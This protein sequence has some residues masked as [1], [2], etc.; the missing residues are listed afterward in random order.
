MIGEII[1]IGDELTSGQRLDTNSQWISQRLGELG[2]NVL[3]HTT[4]ADDLEAGVGVFRAAIERADVIIASGGL[5]PT[6]DDLTREVLAGATGIQLIEDPDAL[7]AIA[8]MFA[9]RGREMPERNK[10]QAL[11]PERSQVIPNPHGTAPGIAM[12]IARELREPCRLFALPGVPAELFEMW[13][14]SVAP[15]IAALP[16][17]RLVICHRRLKCFGIGESQ[18]EAMLPDLI[19]R[20]RS[21]SVGITVHEA[22]ITLRV[23]AAGTTPGAA[24]TLMEP[25]IRTIRE[26]LGHL[27]FG[28]EDDELPD[29]VARLLAARGA[30]LA[31][32]EWGTAGLIADWLG[33][34]ADLRDRYLGGLVVRSRPALQ[35]ILDLRVEDDAGHGVALAEAM[36]ERTRARLE[37][38]YALAVGE[39]PHSDPTAEHPAAC[40]VALAS[41]AGVTS[42]QCP[43][44]G[45]PA[46]LRVL[47]A[48]RALDALRLALLS[49]L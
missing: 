24:Q 11:F 4:T 38:D 6:A 44:A 5:G 45:H 26:S 40:S 18:L 34:V 27:V 39:F 23:T 36:A 3:F 13:H 20:G 22:T 12:Q 29:A 21:P 30:T 15:Q 10:V 28:E 8:A 14:A 47:T 31:T 43:F 2:V 25:T 46:I 17:D 49:N 41:T 42:W 9:R 48:K 1:A 37:A 35:R 32:C 19:R 33:E 7:A 16:S